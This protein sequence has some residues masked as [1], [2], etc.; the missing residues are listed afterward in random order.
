MLALQMRRRAQQELERERM[1]ITDVV[2]DELGEN[3]VYF[4]ELD[5]KPEER[6]NKFR[7][8]DQYHLPTLDFPLEYTPYRLANI[9]EW[10]HLTTHESSRNKNSKNT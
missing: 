7:K 9:D 3:T 4:G 10:R 6:K 2:G 5:M 8:Q 1:G